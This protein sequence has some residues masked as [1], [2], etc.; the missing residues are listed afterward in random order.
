PDLDG[1]R[2]VLEQEH[3]LAVRAERRQAHAAP[4]A[5]KE[6]DL[7]ATFD[8]PNAGGAL[9]R[10]EPLAVVGGQDT[11]AVRAP[12]SAANAGLVVRQ[13]LDQFPCGGVP[14]VRPAVDPVR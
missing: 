9:V 12:G 10:K 7:L 2:A 8:I 4:V 6:G 3:V 13:R 5:L 1:R 14:D 11:L